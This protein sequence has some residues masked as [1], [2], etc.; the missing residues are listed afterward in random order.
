MCLLFKSASPRQPVKLL[1]KKIG[2]RTI[3][4]L[5]QAYLSKERWYSYNGLRL[6][7][8]PQVFHPG[9]FFST[10]LLLNYILKLELKGRSFLELG[11]GSGLI[12]MSA[13]K[14]GAHV[15]ASDINSVAIDYLQHN[16]E[17]NGVDITILKSDLFDDIPAMRFDIIAINPPYYKRKPQNELEHAWFCGEHGEYFVKLFAQ[18]GSYIHNAS[19][20]IMVLCDDCDVHMIESIANRAGYKM[21]LQRATRRLWEMNYIYEIRRM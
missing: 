14:A 6:L 16:A 3:R 15:T 2:G 9:F 8:S 11:A 20:I 18:I 19:D 17:R 13:A 10:R 7:I 21:Q 1:F 5:V 4:P 12:A